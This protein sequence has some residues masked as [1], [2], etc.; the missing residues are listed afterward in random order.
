[1]Y[2]EQLMKMLEL[3]NGKVRRSSSLHTLFSSNAY[4]YMRLAD[5]AAI[6]GTVTNSKHHFRRVSM[7][8]Q[9]D[10]VSFLF[11]AH[12]APNHDLHLVCVH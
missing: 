9:R 2:E 7:A 8:H 1:M 5:H 11:R 6:V 10:Y 12:S 4:T 3:S